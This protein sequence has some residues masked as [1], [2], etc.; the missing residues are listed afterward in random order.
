MKSVTALNMESNIMNTA[1]IALLIR[2]LLREQS[3]LCPYQSNICFRNTSTENKA[4]NA[5]MN[6][7]RPPDKSAYLKIIF[8]Y[9]STKKYDLVTQKNRLNETVLLSTQ[10]ISLN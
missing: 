1:Q 6:D 5:V 2:L 7:G 10:N 8:S 3:D 4:D 9:F